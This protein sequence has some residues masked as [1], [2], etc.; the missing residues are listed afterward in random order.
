MQSEGLIFSEPLRRST[1]YFSPAPLTCVTEAVAKHASLRNTSLLYII[2]MSMK[3]Y[4]IP[5]YEADG[6][7]DKYV[8]GRMRLFRY[9][10]RSDS[11]RI[12]KGLCR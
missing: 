9:S 11:K 6:D 12:Q 3:T 7:K 8:T 10:G 5:V 4:F 2:H 1:L